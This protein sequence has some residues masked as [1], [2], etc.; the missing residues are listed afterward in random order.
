ME[1]RF[2]PYHHSTAHLSWELIWNTVLSP[3]TMSWATTLMSNDAEERAIVTTSMNAIGQAISAWFQL[4]EY[5]AIAAPNFHKASS[6]LAVLL[7][8]RF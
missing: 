4:L 7:Y 8:C 1:V 2:N 3:V 6:S 5:P